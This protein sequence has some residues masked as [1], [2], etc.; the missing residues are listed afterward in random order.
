M[1]TISLQIPVLSSPNSVEDPKIISDFTTLQTLVNGNIDQNNVSPTAVFPSA[2]LGVWN[3]RTLTATSISASNGDFICASATNVAQTV[4]LPTPS[5]GSRVKVQSLFNTG[6]TPCTISTGSGAI[7][8]LGLNA[9]SMKLGT[10]GACV[11]LV[12]SGSNWLIGA[13]EQDTGWVTLTPVSGMS[14]P[15]TTGGYTFAA[16]LRGDRVELRGAVDNV[17]A[18]ASTTI[19]TLPTQF[20]PAA[21]AY[22][23]NYGGSVV[24]GGA[25]VLTSGVVQLGFAITNGTITAFDGVSFSLS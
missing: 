5:M 24:G 2:N 25:N 16:R 21:N 6:A 1:G 8:G 17:S 11:E 7:L 12:G 13:G 10:T 22:F 9:S 4:T 20:R 15:A 19:T 18:G 23:A 14:S 3:V